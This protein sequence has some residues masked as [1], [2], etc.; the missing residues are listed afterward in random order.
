MNHGYIAAL[1]VH[2]LEKRMAAE[3]LKVEQKG[4]IMS[5]ASALDRR[6]MSK[7]HIYV[8]ANLRPR[9]LRAILRKPVLLQSPCNNTVRYAITKPGAHYCNRSA[10]SRLRNAV[11]SYRV[12]DFYIVVRLI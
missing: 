11:T 7:I 1:L 8:A 12:R 4:V 2:V 5:G 6:P 9:P 10:D 3:K